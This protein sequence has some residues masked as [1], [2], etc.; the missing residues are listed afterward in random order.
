MTY[1]LNIMGFFCED[2]R[3]ENDNV[4]TLVGLLP[5]NINIDFRTG[6][7]KDGEEPAPR[8]SN[9]VL[10]KLCFFARTNFDPKE[11]FKTLP[12]FLVFPDGTKMPAGE[13]KEDTIEKAKEKALEHSLPFAGVTIRATLAGLNFPK[14]GGLIRLEADVNGEVQVVAVLNTTIVPKATSSTEHQ[15]PSSQSA[16]ASLATT[17]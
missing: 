8:Q 11:Q 5:D 10:G 9:R 1:L 4:V 17:H 6:T 12:F 16:P 7:T 13:V 3:Q 15:P 14:N 2:I